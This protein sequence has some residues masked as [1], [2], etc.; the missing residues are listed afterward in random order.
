MEPRTGNVPVGRLSMNQIT[1]YRWTMPEDV[2]GYQDAGIPAIGLWRQK[3]V[4]F[5]EER[6][7]DLVLEAG[8]SV[9]SLSYAGG[10]TG[11]FGLSYEEAVE[12]TREAIDLGSSVGAECVVVVSG[13]RGMH[14]ANHSRRLMVDALKSLADR[15]EA[16]NIDLA[17]LPMHRIYSQHW[18]WLSTLD[19]TLE[20]LDLCNHP[21]VRLAF[22]AYHL[23]AEPDLLD[24]IPQIA[25][26]TSVVRISDRRAVPQTYNERQ[27]P[28]DGTLPLA[29]I[30][31]TFNQHGYRG[32][33]EV[34]IWSD[35]IWSG[36]YA[37]MLED[38]RDRFRRLTNAERAIDAAGLLSGR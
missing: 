5:G 12:E 4:D 20:I 11:A 16:K 37:S 34:E 17:V 7:V 32:F 30:L 29:E 38:C 3:L 33:C 22:D 24:R 31:R 15:A 6:A 19:E 35:E 14:T 18:T 10:F 28:G 13:G 25:P 26:L 1:T 21:R 36:D 23:G 9:S 8:M 27:L 2:I